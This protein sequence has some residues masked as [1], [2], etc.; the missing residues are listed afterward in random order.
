MDAESNVYN[1]ENRADEENHTIYT[2]LDTSIGKR[3]LKEALSKALHDVTY[4]VLAS[5]D[6]I[7]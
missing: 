4:S 7:K 6:D 2:M 3:K 1:N 5:P